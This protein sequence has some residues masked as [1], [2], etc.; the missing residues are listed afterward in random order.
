MKLNIKERLMTLGLIP[1]KGN[2]ITLRVVRELSNKVS[3]TSKEIKDFEI[4]SDETGMVRWDSEKTKDLE[5]DIDITE[6]ELGI[7]KSELIKLNDSSELTLEHE[8]IY[9]KFV[10]SV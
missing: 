6:A 9:K 2:I 3:F 1:E 7:I 10:E 8:S 4:S 5:F